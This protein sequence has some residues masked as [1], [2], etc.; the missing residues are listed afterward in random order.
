MLV[1]GRRYLLLQGWQVALM[2]RAVAGPDH[3]GQK[4]VAVLAD[5]TAQQNP[6]DA[7]VG[8]QDVGALQRELLPDLDLSPLKPLERGEV[9][10]WVGIHPQFVGRA[11]PAI[12]SRKQTANPPA[13]GVLNQEPDGLAQTRKAVCAVP[14]PNEPTLRNRHRLHD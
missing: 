10:S 13:R 6:T 3:I 14:L 11:D 8:I 1:N 7:D 4:L 12:I 5:R 9:F 2:H